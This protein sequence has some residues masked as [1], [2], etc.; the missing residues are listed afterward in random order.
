M[1]FLTIFKKHVTLSCKSFMSKV[2]DGDTRNKME[3]CKAGEYHRPDQSQA[4]DRNANLCPSKFHHFSAREGN[5]KF[6]TNVEPRLKYSSVTGP[7]F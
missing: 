7:L 3:N 4:M 5:R 2:L 6:N 1:R